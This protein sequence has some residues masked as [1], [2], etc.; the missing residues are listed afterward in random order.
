MSWYSGDN[1]YLEEEERRREEEERRDRERREQYE[2]E[3]RR[4]DE[5][6]EERARRDQEDSA[7]RREEYRKRNEEDDSCWSK[8]GNDDDYSKNA[9]NYSYSSGTSSNSSGVHYSFHESKSKF[10]FPSL[11]DIFVFM[12]FFILGLVINDIW[13]YFSEWQTNSGFGSITSGIIILLIASFIWYKMAAITSKE[14][15]KLVR[16][17]I[18]CALV[19]IRVAHSGFGTIIFSMVPF[20]VYIYSYL[21]N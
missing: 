8:S 10:K 2:A 13:I 4:Y 16:E 1:P 7:R 12:L 15:S 18:L 3:Q 11:G 5:E 17:V 21:T 19:F 14:T 20:A 6:L 9:E